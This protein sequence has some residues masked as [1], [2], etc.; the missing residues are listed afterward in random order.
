MSIEYVYVH[1]S[2]SP[3]VVFVLCSLGDRVAH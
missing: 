3:S 2:A 1:V